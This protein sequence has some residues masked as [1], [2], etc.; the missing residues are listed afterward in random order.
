MR[1]RITTSRGLRPGDFDS[2]LG[3]QRVC[4]AADGLHLKLEPAP[5]HGGGHI[6][7]AL[8][9]DGDELAGY[10][11]VDFGIDAE[12]CGMVRPDRRRAGCGGALLLA[13]RE[14]AAAAIRES[15][16][17]I[18][19]D[20]SP[21]ALAWLRR[22]GATVAHSE[23]RMLLPMAER[24]RGS[25]HAVRLR[26]AQPED[27]DQVISILAE[28]FDEPPG[29]IGAP[30]LDETLVA[31][32]G[33]RIVGTT[34]LV[35]SPQ[36]WMIYGF[37]VEKAVRGRGF[38]RAMLD[39]TLDMLAADGVDEVGLEAETTNTPALRLYASAGFEPVTTY[40]YMRLG[41]DLRT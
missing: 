35:R 21:M 25:V 10:C 32:D 1:H 7:T 38:G 24:R 39:A 5:A 28:G 9:W 29:S 31:L 15:V 12:V 14:M 34:R 4:E 40:R 33:E 27:R 23:L 18:C 20:A 8:A 17:V 11:G 13:A 3:L 22:L 36:R 19:E 37:V 26:R 30:A 41:A 2:V 16:L 6:D